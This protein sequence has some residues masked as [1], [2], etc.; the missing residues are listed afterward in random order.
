MLPSFLSTLRFTALAFCAAAIA[1]AD[2]SVAG[3][4]ADENGLA[5]PFTRVEFR[6]SAPATPLIANSDITGAFNVS[7]PSA[8]EYWI[9]AGRQGFFVFDGRSEFREGSNQ[10]HVTLNH[11]RDFFQ[12]VDVAYSAP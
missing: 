2:V 6:L 3:R 12:S 11:L 10:L 7:L 9:H 5:I 1:A 8:G 4:V